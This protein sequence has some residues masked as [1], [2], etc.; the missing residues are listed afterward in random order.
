MDETPDDDHAALVSGWS[1]VRLRVEAAADLGKLRRDWATGLI[2]ADA[3]QFSALP[4][5]ASAQELELRKKQADVL[6]KRM[7]RVAIASDTAWQVPAV[8]GKLFEESRKLCELELPR[9][10]DEFREFERR[11]KDLSELVHNIG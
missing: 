2:H 10:D 3:H 5:P 11:L 9:T 8:A 4:L 7:G 6:V 1:S